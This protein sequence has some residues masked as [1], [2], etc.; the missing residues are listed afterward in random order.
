MA[1]FGRIVSYLRKQ[2]KPLF[3]IIVATSEGMDGTLLSD[4]SDLVTVL[5]MDGTVQLIVENVTTLPFAA[6]ALFLIFLTAKSAKGH[7]GGFFKA[8]LAG[9]WFQDE[10]AADR[11]FERRNIS[12]VK[13]CPGCSEQVPMSVLICAG[14]D[15]NFLTG[16][17]GSGQRMLPS[18]EAQVYE[19]RPRNFAYRA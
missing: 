5:G 10:S 13:T 11:M 7:A 18:P 8:L 4:L 1:R 12:A 6:F 16:T 3:G 15:H 19:M 9:D 14:C 17:V 2:L